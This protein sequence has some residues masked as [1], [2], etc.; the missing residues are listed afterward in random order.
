M[1]DTSMSGLAHY[2]INEYYSKYT[3]G[4]RDIVPTIEQIETAYETQKD[5]FVII[6]DENIKGVAVFL[7]LSDKTFEALERYDITRVDVLK[8]LLLE[9]GPNVHFVLLCADGVRTILTGMNEVKRRMNPKTISW[10]N[11]DFTKLHKFK[12]RT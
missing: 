9:G 5:R 2:L 11:P 4:R 7:T 12:V 10:W 1:K 6:R 8:V 3:G